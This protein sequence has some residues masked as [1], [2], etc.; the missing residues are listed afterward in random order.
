M[1]LSQGGQTV[2][3]FPGQ[4]LKNGCTKNAISTVCSIAWDTHHIKKW[5]QSVR[6]SRSY[7]KIRY[8]IKWPWRRDTP[9]SKLKLNTEIS[10]KASKVYIFGIY[11]RRGV[12]NTNFYMNSYKTQKVTRPDRH[13]LLESKWG[14]VYRVISRKQ[15]QTPLKKFLALLEIRIILKNEP[16]RIIVKGVIAKK[17]YRTNWPQSRDTSHSELKLTFWTTYND[18]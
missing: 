7:S 5:D 3:K 10:E 1:F 8:H 14:Q 4:F 13:P 17:K 11:V 16:N 2:V 18:L 12:Q 9:P 15:K 6:S